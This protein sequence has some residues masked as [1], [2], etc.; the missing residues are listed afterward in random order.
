[1]RTPERFSTSHPDCRDL[2]DIEGGEEAV[3]RDCRDALR[4]VR[5]LVLDLH[6]F[7]P[8]R[9]TSP[10]VFELL[11]DVGFTFT[12]DDLAPLPWRPPVAP[13][14]TPFRGTHLCWSAL[15]RA[16]RPPDS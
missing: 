8:S 12:L 14:G 7:D 9:R 15:V 3:L 13:A 16:W 6:E 2:L 1:V 10:A 11:S 5:A 4:N